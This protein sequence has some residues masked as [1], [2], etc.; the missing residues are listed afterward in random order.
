MVDVDDR[1]PIGHLLQFCALV[2]LVFA[3]TL[4]ASGHFLSGLTSL[5][6]GCT[7]AL[8]WFAN[9][10]S[11]SFWGLALARAASILVAGLGLSAI[12]GWQPELVFWTLLVPLFFFLVW[13]IRWALVLNL[14]FVTG[15]MLLAALEPKGLGA[16]RH[17]LVPTLLLVALLTGLFV[18]LREVKVRQL[19]PLR[20]TDTLTLASTQEHLHADL[21]TE[22]QRSERE[23]T[24]LAVVHL[25]LDPQDT[26]LPTAD[27]SA[28]LRQL[29]R[30]LHQELRTFDS[31]YRIDESGFLLILP[32]LETASAMRQADSIR[33]VAAKLMDTHALTLPL[34]AGVTALNVGDDADSLLA[35]A[36][37]ALRRVQVSGGNRTQSW[38]GRDVQREDEGAER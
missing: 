2:L 19:A 9:R 23:G 36:S 14:V 32:C 20:R 25:A 8:G 13:P 11:S 22:I 34:S 27:Q 21:H 4:V 3:T 31:Y 5:A 26:P 18:Y 24:A 1:R 10:S 37:E 17:Q 30:V 38:A 16:L 6:L 29:G 33:L 7:A 28:L 35:R 15:A 12:L